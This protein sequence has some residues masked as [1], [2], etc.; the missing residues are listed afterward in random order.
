MLYYIIAIFYKFILY[1]SEL[2]IGKFKFSFIDIA[3]INNI[4]AKHTQKVTS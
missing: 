1:L 2:N 4:I 3:L